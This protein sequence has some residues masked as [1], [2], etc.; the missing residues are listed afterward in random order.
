[1]RR[2]RGR[3]V[4]RRSRADQGVRYFGVYPDGV[5]R[6]RWEGITYFGIRPTWIRY[7]AFSPGGAVAESSA[8]VLSRS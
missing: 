5:E 1:M 2:R 4:G 7:S 6:Q 8:E 3:A